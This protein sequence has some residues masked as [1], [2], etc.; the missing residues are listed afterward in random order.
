MPA[1]CVSR[2]E[3]SEFLLGKMEPE[4]L[5]RISEHVDACPSCQDTVAA[6]DVGDTFIA[7]L[8]GPPL[9]DER[10]NEG[11]LRRSLERLTPQDAGQRAP[12]EIPGHL[13]LQNQQWGPYELHELRGRG[14]MGAVYRA[15][16]GKLKRTVAVKV[17]SPDRFHD[18][19][20]VARFE[21]EWRP[22][23]N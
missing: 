7:S 21:R 22:S 9:M 12:R 4:Q 16:H 23:G 14:G 17:L 8:Q 1:T 18:P 11:A 2:E 5:D 10:L 13:R 3:L 15:T 6:L 19:H 20:H